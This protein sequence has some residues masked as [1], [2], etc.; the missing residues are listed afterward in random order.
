AL[1]SAIEA[2]LAASDRSAATAP[3]RTRALLCGRLVV[4]AIRV[5]HAAIIPELRNLAAHLKVCVRHRRCTKVGVELSATIEA[6]LRLAIATTVA[7]TILSMFTPL[8]LS[9]FWNSF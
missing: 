9:I 1:V 4:A 3:P 6:S 8:A 5:L 7:P 2:A